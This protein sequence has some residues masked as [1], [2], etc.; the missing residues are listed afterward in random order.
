[1]GDTL[2]E[3]KKQVLQRGADLLGTLLLPYGFAFEVLGAGRCSG[4]DFAFGNFRHGDRR[5]EL[6][7]RDSLGMVRYLL[8]SSSMTHENYMYA[9][10]GAWHAS[11]YPGFSSDPMDGFRDLLSDLKDY[12]SDFVSGTDDCLSRRIE[13]ANLLAKSRPL[14]PD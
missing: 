5:I 3:D 8:G 9:V 12:G 14:L 6:H 10:L 13:E 1:M 11:R 7:F 2:M 4:G